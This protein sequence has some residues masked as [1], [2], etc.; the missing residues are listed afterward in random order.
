MV[1]SVAKLPGGVGKDCGRNAITAV[2]G[3]T[4]PE[5]VADAAA[6]AALKKSLS[7]S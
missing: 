7:L 4:A 3:R 1:V 5:C 6:S 2:L